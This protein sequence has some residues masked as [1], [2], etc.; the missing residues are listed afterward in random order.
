MSLQR[1]VCTSVLLCLIDA[2]SETDDWTSNT[3]PSTKANILLQSKTSATVSSAS[4]SD[5]IC[6]PWCNTKKYSA[7]PMVK[8]CSWKNCNGCSGCR[9]VPSPPPPPALAPVARCE[10]WCKDHSSEWHEKCA[11]SSLKCKNCFPCKPPRPT[12]AP[13]ST[14]ESFYVEAR[15]IVPGNSVVPSKTRFL[16]GEPINFTFTRSDPR[17]GRYMEFVG[18]FDAQ[19]LKPGKDI[20]KRHA[21]LAVNTCGTARCKT[22]PPTHG[23]LGFNN[24]ALNWSPVRVYHTSLYYRWPWP[25][26]VGCY[27][28]GLFGSKPGHNTNKNYLL[29]VSGVFAVG[30]EGMVTCSPTQWQAVSAGS[31]MSQTANLG[32]GTGFSATAHRYPT[33]ARPWTSFG[34][35]KTDGEAGRLEIKPTNSWLLGPGTFYGPYGLRKYFYAVKRSDGCEGFFWQDGVQSDGHVYGELKVTWLSKDLASMNTTTVLDKDG[36]AMRAGTQGGRLNAVAFNDDRDEAILFVGG[37]DVRFLKVNLFDMSIILESTPI[38]CADSFGIKQGQQVS[39]GWSSTNNLV[40]VV[41]QGGMVPSH[42]GARMGIINSTDLTLIRGG[43]DV[44]SHNAGNEVGVFSDGSFWYTALGDQ[45]PRGVKL[46]RYKS[47]SDAYVNVPYK[48]KRAKMNDNN[49]YS[50]LARPGVV[51]TDGGAGVILFFTGENPSLD[52]RKVGKPLNVARQIGYVKMGNTRS[53]RGQI[54]SGSNFEFGVQM[55]GSNISQ[56]GVRWLTDYPQQDSWRSAFNLKTARLGPGRILLYWEVWSGSTYQ[57]SQVMIVNDDAAIVEGPWGLS[58]RM[59]TS[60]SD[61]MFVTE[62]NRTVIFTGDCD[63]TCPIIGG[64]TSG[65]QKTQCYLVRYQ[66]CAGANC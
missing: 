43:F 34:G 25:F 64:K 15:E 52:P 26:R 58:G 37:Y 66:V 1:L 30:D 54:L 57:K 33:D 19:K 44:T 8:K 11:W 38:N 46:A 23:T 60:W 6:K 59:G 36:N 18:I 21:I 20:L 29:A 9:T 45:Y 63:W 51:E 39:M 17:K 55:D 49:C 62:E 61:N 40:S 65:C 41:V 47:G 4:Y 24:T 5:L 7:T 56:K 35:P 13:S 48:Y 28:L 50:T 42:Q 27:T 2:S 10:G 22:F 16:P 14:P 53:T 31:G 3:C 12:A 32:S